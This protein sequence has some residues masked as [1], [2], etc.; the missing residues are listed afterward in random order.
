MTYSIDWMVRLEC[1]PKWVL[2]RLTRSMI[3]LSMVSSGKPESDS[4]TTLKKLIFANES[5]LAHRYYAEPYL[6]LLRLGNRFKASQ[7]CHMGWSETCM[8][9]RLAPKARSA[10]RAVAMTPWKQNYSSSSSNGT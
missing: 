8:P 2:I 1:E 9:S 6:R 3:L 10:N 5:C 7:N 4:K